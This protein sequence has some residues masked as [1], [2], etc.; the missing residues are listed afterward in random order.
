MDLA[1]NES[2]MDLDPPQIQEAIEVVIVDEAPNQA[3]EPHDEQKIMRQSKRKQFNE[4]DEHH[5]DTDISNQ[6]EFQL[7]KTVYPFFSSLIF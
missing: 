1:E 5:R 6:H 3:H 7:Q 4:Q 2:S